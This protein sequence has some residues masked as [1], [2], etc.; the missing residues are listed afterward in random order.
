MDGTIELEWNPFSTASRA[1]HA[2]RAGRVSLALDLYTR[3][4]QRARVRACLQRALP[5]WPVRDVLLAASVELLDLQALAAGIDQRSMPEVAG[6]LTHVVEDG[7]GIAGALWRSAERMVTA[8]GLLA[9]SSVMPRS[10]QRETA[11]LER[12]LESIRET[13]SSLADLA[14]TGG[15][16]GRSDR[17]TLETEFTSLRRAADEL[18]EEGEQ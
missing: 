13:R 6:V 12:L 10:L 16:T 9:G 2:E 15:R 1:A 5:A 8:A 11:K 3:A 14:L 4:G 17:Q 18:N 7:E